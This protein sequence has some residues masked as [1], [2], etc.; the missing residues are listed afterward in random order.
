VS[1]NIPQV[2]I[3]PKGELIPNPGENV[4]SSYRDVHYDKWEGEIYITDSRFVW[5]GLQHK[6]GFLGKLAKAAVVAGVA[7][8]AGYAAS[9]AGPRVGIPGRVAGIG[10]GGL[11]GLTVA[12]MMSKHSD[13][14]PTT[15]SI[16]YE[17]VS[18]IDLGKNKKEI[19]M[20]T[21]VG[22]FIFRFE[23]GGADTVVTV[24]KA[25]H[26]NAMKRA[27]PQ[28]APQYAPQYEPQYGPPP[29]QYQPP[30]P[31]APRRGEAFY[32][33]HCGTPLDPGARFCHNCGARTDT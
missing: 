22:S 17:V 12:S 10:G 18:S 23:K 7:V 8:A 5:I 27:P 19:T 25:Q 9:K 13:G 28:P 30:P 14:T 3:S 21:Q 26:M 33:P 32:C 16:P 6:G 1:Y 15:I 4:V 31:P 11:A 24:V 2:N 20:A 29:P